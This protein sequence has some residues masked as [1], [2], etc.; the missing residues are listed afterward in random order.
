MRHKK[1]DKKLKE[2][3]NTFMQVKIVSD[4]QDSAQKNMAIDKKLLN[5]TT[6]IPIIRLYYWKTLSL[7]QAFNKKIPPNLQHLDYSL[8][9][10]GGGMVIHAPTDILI[11]FILPTNTPYLPKKTK[12][13]LIHIKNIFK[14]FLDK[15]S[16]PTTPPAHST[17]TTIHLCQNYP[18]PFELYQ[19][20][21]KCLA[22][23]ARLFRKN[24]LIQ[25]ILHCSNQLKYKDQLPN[26]YH[27]LLSPG[28]PQA[29]CI[30][31]LK[32]HLKKHLP[33][34]DTPHV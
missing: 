11:T 22:L 29:T 18:S 19:K 1:L 14:E 16:L 10:T 13:T 2:L 31:Q 12:H 33:I 5:E 8:R 21:K 17:Q 34:T 4:P 24:I 27:P 3:L 9:P 23:A 30:Q 26:E 32:Y 28:L 25:S 7:T 20:Q 15:R 6:N